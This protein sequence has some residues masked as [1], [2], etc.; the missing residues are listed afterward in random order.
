MKTIVKG[1]W[2]VIVFG[3]MFFVLPFATIPGMFDTIFVVLGGF[4]FVILGLIVIS[5]I[6]NWKQ[7]TPPA[8][9]AT[10]VDAN[11]VITSTNGHAK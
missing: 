5:V 9:Q 10:I 3:L 4:T 11:H 6:M 2:P 7:A 8:K 1:Q